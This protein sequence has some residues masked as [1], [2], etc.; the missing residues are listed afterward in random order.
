L[1]SNS[2][3]V[4]INK[5]LCIKTGILICIGNLLFFLKIHKNNLKLVGSGKGLNSEGLPGISA[6][7]AAGQAGGRTQT[8]SRVGG[9]TK[10]IGNSMMMMM[11]S[12]IVI[13]PSGAE[14]GM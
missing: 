13:L 12:M 3:F 11:L 5:R 14:N 7:Q 4:F 9:G 8:G 10:G 2:N 1:N 6:R